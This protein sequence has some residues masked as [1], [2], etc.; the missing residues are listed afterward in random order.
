MADHRYL[1]ETSW[2]RVQIAVFPVPIPFVRPLSG[3]LA[4][5]ESDWE[6]VSSSRRMSAPVLGF[7]PFLHLVHEGKCWSEGKGD[8]VLRRTA[9]RFEGVA[10][11]PVR[12]CAG[13]IL[14]IGGVRASRS[15]QGREF[16]R[17]GAPFSRK[18]LFSLNSIKFHGNCGIPPFW[19]L[20]AKSATWRAKAPFGAP[21]LQVACS[22]WNIDGFGSHFPPKSLLGRKSS[23]FTK[24]HTFS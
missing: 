2:D 22:Q 20:F 5:P 1:H 6:R 13:P 15:G 23:H 12:V 21:S 11:P 19:G 9:L 7:G 18:V 14:H 4:D 16:G 10:S 8:A 3:A 24:N 17:R